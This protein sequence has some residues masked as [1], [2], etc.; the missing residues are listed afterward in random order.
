MASKPATPRKTIGSIGGK[1]AVWTLKG[2]L[3]LWKLLSAIISMTVS[4]DLKDF[5]IR[6]VVIL[7]NV[8]FLIEHDEMCQNK[9]DMHGKTM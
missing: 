4:K 7:M 9:E 1:K 3:K 6:L 8:I 5:L 2:K